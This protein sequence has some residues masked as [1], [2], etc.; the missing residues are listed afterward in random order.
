MGETTSASRSEVVFSFSLCEGVHQGET[1]KTFYKYRGCYVKIYTVLNNRTPN[2]FIS[3][4]L[5]I[6][7]WFYYI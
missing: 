4:V 7:Y 6:S 1:L 5:V 3:F 2:S